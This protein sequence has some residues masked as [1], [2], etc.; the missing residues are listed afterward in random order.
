MLHR[1]ILGIAFAALSCAAL[2][3]GGVAAVESEW[4]EPRI[5]SWAAERLERSVGLDTID[6]RAAWP[7][8]L[9][10]GRL[11]VSNPKWATSPT[12][13]EV[14]GLSATFGV[15]GWFDGH[16]V[17]ERLGVERLWADLERDGRR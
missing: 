11:R 4:A 14:E 5:A 1:V 13:L 12:L 9:T 2:L 7:P 8:R 16:A 17:V 3:L 15:A 6:I 10:I